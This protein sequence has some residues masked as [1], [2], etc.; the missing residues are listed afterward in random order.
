MARFKPA[1]VKLFLTSGAEE[2]FAAWRKLDAD[3]RDACAAAVEPF[4]AYCR[5]H[6]GYPPIHACRFIS[7]GRYVQ[8]AEQ[9]KGKPSV[10]ISDGEWTRFLAFARKDRKW[11]LESWGPMPGDPS[12]RVPAH[13]LQPNDGQSWTVWEG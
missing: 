1:S 5:A 13:L 4:A 6:P 7:K 12:C 2:A 9:A 8:F 10:G 11:H 3:E